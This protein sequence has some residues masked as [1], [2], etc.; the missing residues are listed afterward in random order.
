M[1]AVP[2]DLQLTLPPQQEMRFGLLPVL[3]PQLELLLSSLRA[4]LLVL[5]LRPLLQLTPE[6]ELRQR[7]MMPLQPQPLR[8]L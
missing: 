1:L 2:P 4:L 3:Q 5:W 7:L 8:R 6:H